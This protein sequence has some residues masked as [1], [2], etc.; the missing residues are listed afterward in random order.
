[1]AEGEISEACRL[2]P[3]NSRFLLEREQLLRRLGRPVKERLALLEARRELLPDRYA[4]MLAYVSLLNQVFNS[5]A[6]SLDIINSNVGDFF[7]LSSILIQ[8]SYGAE[9]IFRVQL[10]ECCLIMSKRASQ[11]DDAFHFLLRHNSL[12]DSH[13]IVVIANVSQKCRITLPEHIVLYD[14]DHIRKKR[15]RNTFH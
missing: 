10:V 14:P 1:M 8:V 4:L 12:S 3:G 6:G 11:K 13:L 15:I 5:L 2:E 7:I 9:H